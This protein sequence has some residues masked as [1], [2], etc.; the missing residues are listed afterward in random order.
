MGGLL[1]KTNEDSEEYY[2]YPNSLLYDFNFLY[3]HP[4]RNIKD[5][6][7]IKNNGLI[8]I[9]THKVINLNTNCK[10]IF[11][12][13]DGRLSSTFRKKVFIFQENIKIKV[14]SAH[15]EYIFYHTQLSNGNIITCSKD[16]TMKIISIY[17]YSIIQTFEHKDEVY[18]VVERN[19][20]Q[21][22]S[23]TKNGYIHFWEKKH[24]NEK[25]KYIQ[26]FK[27]FEESSHI[28]LLL[29]NKNE[30]V[31]TN[32]GESLIQFWN[33]N[34]NQTVLVLKNANKIY[35]DK[36]SKILYTNDVKK[37]SSNEYKETG[38]FNI[39]DTKKK[40][41]IGHISTGEKGSYITHCLG[42]NIIFRNINGETVLFNVNY[43]KG[44]EEITYRTINCSCE[45]YYHEF[46][47]HNNKLKTIHINYVDEYKAP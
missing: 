34:T 37:D 33:L 7:R 31:I 16:K 32:E 3:F 10:N 5:K 23:S 43:E 36:I 26:K 17:D 47:F 38:K 11:Y 15:K 9:N 20:N 12:L 44:N 25:Y 18:R 6:I 41:L 27:V 8:K 28:N 2:A 46:F 13:K 30:L 45:G 39:I 21:I 42:N 24:N 14:I 22:I 35:F 40:I 1:P 29:I 19:N 4:Q